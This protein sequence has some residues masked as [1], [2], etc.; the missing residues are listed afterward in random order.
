[1]ENIETCAVKLIDQEKV[2][3]VVSCLADL[4]TTESMSGIFK[5]LADP[6]RLRIVQA[7]IL[8]ELC[9]CDISAAI[10]VSI[11][12]TSHQL[13]LLRNLRIVKNRKEGK[14]VFYSINDDHIQA[15]IN[16]TSEHVMEEANN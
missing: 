2:N 10:D 3:R 12:A 4:D 7:L 5:A 9:V 16:L 13:R 15:L 11:S 6:T 14:M 8:E 1:M